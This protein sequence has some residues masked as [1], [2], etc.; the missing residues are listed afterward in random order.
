MPELKVK[1]VKGSKSSLQ[2]MFGD[3]LVFKLNDRR[4]KRGKAR[5]GAANSKLDFHFE[6]QVDLLNGKPCLDV[7]DEDMS[8][9]KNEL[10]SNGDGKISTAELQRVLSSTIIPEIRM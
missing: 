1:W 10:D 7:E 4:T 3:K 8:Y 2:D 6:A 5:N 9:L